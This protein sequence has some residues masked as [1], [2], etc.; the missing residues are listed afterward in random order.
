MEN[1]KLL[2]EP[3]TYPVNSVQEQNKIFFGEKNNR[4]CIYC[5]KTKGEVT[6]KKDAHV[7]P[8]ALGNRILFNYDECDSCNEHYFGVYENELANYLMLDRIF[9]GARKRNGLP[10]Y[11][12]NSRGDTSIEH[13]PNSNTVSIRID[14]L[15]GKFEILNDNKNNEMIYKINNP[16]SYRPADICKTLTH[17]IWPFLPEKQRGNL[18]HLPKWLLGDI[19]IFPLHL[20]VAFVPGTGYSNVILECWVS[21]DSESKYP[22]MVRFTFGTKILSFYVPSSNQISELPNRFIDYIQ[23]PEHIDELKVDGLIIN[24]NT[25]LKPSHLTYTLKYSDIKTHNQNVEDN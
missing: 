23:I 16:I 25:R 12:P 1:Y 9:I 22:I 15:E 2:F 6:F 10:K 24:D 11:K 8:A 21:S 4:R 19:E 14:D 5:G 13:L 17:M 3:F 7:V 18:D 20:D